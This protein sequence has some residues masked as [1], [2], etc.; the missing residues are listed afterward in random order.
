MSEKHYGHLLENWQAAKDEMRAILIE[1]ARQRQTITYGELCEAIKTIHFRPDGY[2]LA[3]M[4]R[5]ISNEDVAAGRG[6]LATLVVR[7][8]S[9]RPGPG[10][11]K[12]ML[13]RGMDSEALEQFWQ[14][15][16]AR[17]CRDWQVDE[18]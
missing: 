12:G 11:F 4:L 6:Y 2:G 18:A 5:E 9:G 17:T 7:K 8:S 3:G 15:E 14:E 10:Y 1:R 13:A 16:F